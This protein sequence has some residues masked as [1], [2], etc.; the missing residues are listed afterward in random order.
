LVHFIES[1]L[2][3]ILVEHL[4]FAESPL[5]IDLAKQVFGLVTTLREL[6]SALLEEL[7][8]PAVAKWIYCSNKIELV[9]IDEEGMQLVSFSL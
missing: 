3:F 8:T 1:V 5:L 7:V 4:K 6:D 9:E 2:L